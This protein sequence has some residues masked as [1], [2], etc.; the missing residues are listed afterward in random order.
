[1]QLARNKNSLHHVAALIPPSLLVSY[2]QAIN[3]SHKIN[4]CMHHVMHA[5]ALGL[6]HAP[7]ILHINI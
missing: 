6:P 7:Q 5:L 2:S 1:M 3:A 4:S